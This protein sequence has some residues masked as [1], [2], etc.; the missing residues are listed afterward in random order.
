MKTYKITK[1]NFSFSEKFMKKMAT[2]FN[3]FSSNFWN[4][5]IDAGVCLGRVQSVPNFGGDF[6]CSLINSPPNYHAYVMRRLES[7]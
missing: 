2:I 6:I 5:T 4:C 1:K 3:V 7:T